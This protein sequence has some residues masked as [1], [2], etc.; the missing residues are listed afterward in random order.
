MSELDS[1]NASLLRDMYEN[2]RLG[3]KFMSGK[4]LADLENDELLAYAV[5]HALQIIGEAANHVTEDIRAAFPNVEWA[6][7]IGMRNRV[8]HGYNVINYD[9]VWTVV[10][11]N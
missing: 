5:V 6:A 7:I 11:E 4:T 8:V 1:R 3:I 10:Q 2:A 9:I